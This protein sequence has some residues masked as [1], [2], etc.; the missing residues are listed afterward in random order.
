[1]PAVIDASVV[2]EALLGGSATAEALRVRLARDTCHAP[3]LIDAEV[4]HALRRRVLRGELPAT[5]AEGQLAEGWALIDRRYEM[6]GRLSLAAWAL[7]ENLSFYDALYAA[8]AASLDCP[9]LTADRRIARAAGIPCE[10]QLIGA[11]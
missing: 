2:V 10:V 11:P 9:L 4:G 7:R 1:M 5:E 8:L 3:S 6:H